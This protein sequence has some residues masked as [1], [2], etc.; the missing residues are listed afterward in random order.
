VPGQG[1]LRFARGLVAQGIG[2][3]DSQ[4]SCGVCC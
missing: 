1:D 3:V 4:G 2:S